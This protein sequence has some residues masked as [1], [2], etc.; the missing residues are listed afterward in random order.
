MF[1]GKT[2]QALKVRCKLLESM[3]NVTRCQC[4]EAIT[5]MMCLCLFGLVISV[6]ALLL[7]L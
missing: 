3:Q 5:Q 2:I 7:T 1:R 6:K 4:N